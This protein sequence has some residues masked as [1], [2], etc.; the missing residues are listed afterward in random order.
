MI[1]TNMHTQCS[2]KE[3]ET[4]EY[5]VI[6]ICDVH[7]IVDMVAEVVRQDTAQDVKCDV[8][9]AQREVRGQLSVGVRVWPESAIR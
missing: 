9:P 1:C 3:R 8:G 5:L 6:N 2:H 4:G 7:Y